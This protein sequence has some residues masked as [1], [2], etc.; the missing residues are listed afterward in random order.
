MYMYRYWPIVGIVNFWTFFMYWDNSSQ[1]SW[2]VKFSFRYTGAINGAAIFKN[3]AL[4]WGMQDCN[5]RLL[6]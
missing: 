6:A 2:A 4:I 1:L 3:L 5:F